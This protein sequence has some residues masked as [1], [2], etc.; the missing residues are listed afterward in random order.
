M[1]ER[2][3]VFTCHIAAAGFKKLIVGSDFKYVSCVDFTDFDLF[4]FI[5]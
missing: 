2:T 4:L 3:G 1:C 5:Y